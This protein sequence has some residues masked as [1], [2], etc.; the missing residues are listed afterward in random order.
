LS[1]EKIFLNTFVDFDRAQAAQ[2]LGAAVRIAQHWGFRFLVAFATAIA[3]FAYV[4][5][6]EQLKA[7]DAAM[8]SAKVRAG[9]MLVHAALAA[10]LVPLSYLLYRDGAA[11]LPFGTVAA[12]WVVLGLGAA[13]SAFSAMAAWSSGAGPRELSGSSGA[14]RQSRRW[15]RPARC[16]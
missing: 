9:W 3:L 14:M 1:R 4:S 8:R 5:G 16:S 11:P 2:G 12:L 13:V 10:C 6:G 7:A 15:S